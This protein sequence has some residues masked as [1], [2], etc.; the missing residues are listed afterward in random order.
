M[1]TSVLRTGW[2]P[3]SW[4]I[5]LLVLAAGYLTMVT[6]TG[7]AIDRVLM[8]MRFGV[9]DR[10]ASGKVAI[11][12][13]DADSAAA[14]ARWPWSRSHYAAVVDRLRKAGAASI[15]FDV[16]FS[17]PSDAAGDRALAASLSRADGRVAL[18]T[19]GQVAGS[20]D[21]RTIDALPIP[22]LRDH[23]ILASVSI[24]PDPD[25][26]VRNM[27]MA[28]VTAGQPRPS[29]SAFIA[30]RSGAV[31]QEFPIDMSIDPS[32][33]PRLS[34]VAV[35]DGRFD[36]SRVRGRNVLVGATAIEMGDRYGT[37]QWGVIPGVVVQ[38]LAAETLIRGVPSYGSPLLVFLLAGIVVCVMLRFRTT[39]GSTV[40]MGVSLCVL[41]PGVLL[42]QQYLLITYPIATAALMMVLTGM[43]CL[44]RDVIGRFKRQR[45]VDEATGLPNSRQLLDLSSRGETIVL[46]VAQI[47][48]YD[49]LRAVLGER[50]TADV[51]L[52]VSERL[53][54]VGERGQ[55]YRMS[56]PQLAFCLPLDQSIDDA[57]H[58]LRTIMLQQ[59]EV[60]GRRV[61]VAMTIGIATGPC[62]EMERVIADA[63]LAAEDARA[64]DL[65]WK[66]AQ[67]DIVGLERSI[68]LMGELDDAI[69]T[70]QIEV[71]YQPKYDLRE[72]CITS[73][74]A[75]VRWRHPSRGFVGPDLFIPVAEKTNRIAPLTLHV[76]S[77]VIRDLAVLRAQHPQ[78]TAA[79]NISAKLLS[80]SSFNTEVERLIAAAGTPASALVFEVTESAA[81]ADTN[82]AVAAL[83]RYRALGIAVSMD[84]YGTGQSTLSYLRQLP[85]NELKI[86]RSFVQ[87]AHQNPDDA[88]LVR[89]TIE[90]AHRLGLKVVAEGVEDDAC[91]EFLRTSGCDMIQGYLISKPVP[92]QSLATILDSHYRYA[93]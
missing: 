15:V 21:Q 11:V 61:D 40:V 41:I 29:L 68:S 62:V 66:R 43:A 47:G 55:V 14:I 5:C 73:V 18:P 42:A 28:T 70:G 10:Q 93:A 81:M 3:S 9:V 32:T 52:R 75:L 67:T 57:L 78:L 27:T 22:M 65:F 72:T 60:G 63:S 53:A 86:D 76:L 83:H 24:R 25:G 54:L 8:P 91:F 71:F 36:A 13:M 48:N 20:D 64:S 59:V 26:Q 30:A 51:V 38:A 79:I 69:A 19:F 7:A 46:A 12:E 34:F 2:R 92:L 33:I 39:I 56:D 87:H 74:E 50:G 16:D 31:D 84:D 89:S 23:A 6:A 77:H 85:L 88:I 58:G 4:V 37:P 35:R 1:G 45:S 90:L 80:S 82:K 44:V 49:P 17:S